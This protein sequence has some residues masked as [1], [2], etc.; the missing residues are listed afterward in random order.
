M[1]VPGWQLPSLLLYDVP[2]CGDAVASLLGDDLRGV[3][4]LHDAMVNA[5]PLG[6]VQRTEKG[7]M[8]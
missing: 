8:S 6:L 1:G 4:F 2:D 3:L 5:V 7:R